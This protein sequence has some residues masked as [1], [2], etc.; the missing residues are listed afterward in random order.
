MNLMLE[1]IDLD[2]K[3]V[4]VDWT[5]SSTAFPTSMRSHDLF[6][7]ENGKIARLEIIDTGMPG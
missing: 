7:I 5:C 4:R 1:R 6:T 3:L 2:G